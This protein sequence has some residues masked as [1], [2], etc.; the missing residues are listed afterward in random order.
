[1]IHFFP[2]PRWGEEIDYPCAGLESKFI[3]NKNEGKWRSSWGHDWS[4]V[5]KTLCQSLPNG[6]LPGC[7]Q[8]SHTG[9]QLQFWSACQHQRTVVRAPLLFLMPLFSWSKGPCSIPTYSWGIDIVQSIL[10]LWATQGSRAAGSSCLSSFWVCREI[11]LPQGCSWTVMKAKHSPCCLHLHHCT[12][13]LYISELPALPRSQ[14]HYCPFLVFTHCGDWLQVEPV[15]PCL[16]R[17]EAESSSLLVSL[18]VALCLFLSFC[19]LLQWDSSAPASM[20]AGISCSHCGW[21]QDLRYVPYSPISWSFN[22]GDLHCTVDMSTPFFK[23]QLCRTYGKSPGPRQ[24]GM[25]FS[26]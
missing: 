26:W 11:V 1:M 20:A 25:F 4:C 8:Q 21:G 2:V 16:I 5:L 23:V 3:T 15:S 18:S 10:G 9:V 22:S 7:A 24:W 12:Y 6:E 14:Q 17:K 13:T 19:V